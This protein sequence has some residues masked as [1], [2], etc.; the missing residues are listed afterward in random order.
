M[1][2]DEVYIDYE[3]L[4]SDPKIIIGTNYCD[5]GFQIDDHMNRIVVLC[6]LD[7]LVKGTAGNAVQCMNIMCGFPETTGLEF[8]G[9]FPL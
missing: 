9:Y 2:L 6:T 5:V 3:A 1:F 4:K 7:N 8:P